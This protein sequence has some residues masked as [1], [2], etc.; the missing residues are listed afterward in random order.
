MIEYNWEF[1]SSLQWK[2]PEGK[3][4]KITC[5]SSSRALFIHPYK[6][7]RKCHSDAVTLILMEITLASFTA[8]KVGILMA[9]IFSCIWCSSYVVSQQHHLIR[10]KAC[11][12]KSIV[13]KAAAATPTILQPSASQCALG[14]LGKG[15]KQHHFLDF[16]SAGNQKLYGAIE[17]SHLCI[18]PTHI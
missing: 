16:S 9:C 5:N 13:L 4:G 8:N 11:L 12:S 15:T 17:W 2:F 1:N 7:A 10:T 3:Q 14:T 18:H 6:S